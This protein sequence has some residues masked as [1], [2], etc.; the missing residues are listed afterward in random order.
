MFPADDRLSVARFVDDEFAPA[1]GTLASKAG[2]D[3]YPVNAE[4]NRCPGE[5]AEGRQ[6]IGDIHDAIA[7]G[8]RL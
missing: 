8:A 5:V 1:L 7:V 2:G 3:G 6:E 4:R